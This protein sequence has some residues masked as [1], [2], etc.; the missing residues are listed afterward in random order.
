MPLG[1]TSSKSCLAWL[2]KGVSCVS[3]PRLFPVAFNLVKAFLTEVTQKKIVI[4]GG[5]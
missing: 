1:M 2:P 3:A 4:L 5:E